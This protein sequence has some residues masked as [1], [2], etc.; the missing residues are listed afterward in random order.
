[1]DWFLLH[2]HTCSLYE[3]LLWVI[4]L[5][6]WQVTLTKNICILEKVEYKLWLSLQNVP[7]HFLDTFG[8]WLLMQV[9]IPIASE[10]IFFTNQKPILWQFFNLFIELPLTI[11]AQV[12]KNVWSGVMSVN[13][14]RCESILYRKKELYPEKCKSMHKLKDYFP[15]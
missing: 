7:L 14:K 2:R 9:P 8:L 3:D 5:T 15:L 12:Q 4:T 11:L 1:M 6:Y 13:K 10:V